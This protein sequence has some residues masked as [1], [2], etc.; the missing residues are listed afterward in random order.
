MDPEFITHQLNVDLSYHLES[1]NHYPVMP[2]SLK[3]AKATY[4]RMNTRMFREKIEHTVEVYIDDMVVKSKEDQR[5]VNDLANIFKVLRHHRLRLNVDKCVFG[6]GASK[7]LGY[8]ITH[9]GIE[10]NPDQ[11]SAIERLKPP[12]NPKEV[13]VLTGM[14]AALNRFVSKSTNQCRPFY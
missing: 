10:V 11:I 1:I 9:R 13:Q 2:F 4:Q 6:V 14:L 8:I 7:F 3:N 12:S 5:H